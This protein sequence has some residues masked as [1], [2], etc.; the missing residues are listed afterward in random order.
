MDENF[1]PY[2]DQ[3]GILSQLGKLDE[4]LVKQ[5]IYTNGQRRLLSNDNITAGTGHEADELT[6][7][8]EN[9]SQIEEALMEPLPAE[10][11]IL[12]SDRL[13]I[14]KSGL[15]SS[16]YDWRRQKQTNRHHRHCCHS[17]PQ[18]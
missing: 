8:Q 14:P 18:L 11:L 16:A 4:D 7:L 5:F 15:P 2:A 12:Q 1:E 17:E 6:L 10:I 3:W 13:Y 9:P